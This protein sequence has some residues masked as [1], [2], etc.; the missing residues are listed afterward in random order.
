MSETTDWIE[1]PYGYA[2]FEKNLPHI[3]PERVTQVEYD[4]EWFPAKS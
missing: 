3:T 4:T 2:N 1:K